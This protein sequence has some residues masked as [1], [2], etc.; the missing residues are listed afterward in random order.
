MR[1]NHIVKSYD[2]D[3]KQLQTTVISMAD[4]VHMQFRDALSSL[5]TGN[6]EKAQ[7]VI[8][9]DQEIDELES[10]VDRLALQ[11]LALRQPVAFDLRMVIAS[12]KMANH[13][14]RMADYAAH[15][16][17]RVLLIEN[18]ALSPPLLLF[19]MGDLIREMM[20]SVCKGFETQDKG[21][22]EQAWQDDQ[23]VDKLY[24]ALLRELL[25][26][27]MEEPRRIGLCTHYLFIAKNIERVGDHVTNLG[28][29]VAIMVRG[30][31]LRVF[32]SHFSELQPGSLE[33]DKKP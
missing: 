22:M 7:R 4:L 30:K 25:T 13:L 29:I 15:I 27:M 18:P 1:E 5:E 26:Y 2:E 3:L 14:E 33:K 9:K 6:T 11:I 28:E 12:L 8:E 21:V 16:S 24:N 23:E 10:L 20:V 19:R 32:R 31:P 17:R